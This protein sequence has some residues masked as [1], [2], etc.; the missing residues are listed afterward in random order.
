MK[1]VS[2]SRRYNGKLWLEVIVV[3]FLDALTTVDVF[4]VNNNDVNLFKTRTVLFHSY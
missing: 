2:S 4:T 3:N 1:N